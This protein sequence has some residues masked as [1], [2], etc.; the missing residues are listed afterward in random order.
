MGSL[1]FQP[2]NIDTEVPEIFRDCTITGINPVIEIIVVSCHLREKDDIEYATLL[3]V[4]S[5]EEHVFSVR[6]G[7]LLVVHKIS[8][9]LHFL[10]NMFLE[11]FSEESTFRWFLQ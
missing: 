8:I 11:I 1:P 4:K 9:D 6:S 2:F 5:P 7:V 3:V 10:S